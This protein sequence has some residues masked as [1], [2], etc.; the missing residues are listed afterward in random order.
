MK[1][2]L[3]KTISITLFSA[4]FMPLIVSAVTGNTNINLQVTGTPT[5][6][7]TPV[8][9]PG[10]YVD[11]IPPVIYSLS[12]SRITF[13]SAV[14]EWKTD[15]PALCQ[16]FWGTTQE[17]KEGIVSETAFLLSHTTSLI[18]LSVETN[19]NFKI[20]CR[21]SKGNESE[22]GNQRFTTLSLPDTTA[23]SNISNFE[24]V[25]GDKQITLQW[26]NPTDSDF[27]LVRIM[28]SQEFYP[29]NP[30]EG[31]LIFEGSTN[32]FTDTSLTNGTRYYYTAFSYD[33]AGNF[34][35][36]AV[37]SA[38]PRL[39]EIPPIEQIT[40]EKQ[41]LE[42]GFYW[43]DNSC[44]QEQQVIP[45]PPEVEKLTLDDFDFIQKGIKLFET[46][47]NINI[48][49]N[50]PL[51]IS[52]D[53]GKV[54][55]V[56]KT[57]MVTLKKDNKTFSFL[58]RINQEKTAYLA[59]L[60]P[61]SETGAYPAILSVLDY[62]NQILKKVSTQLTVKETKKPF[63]LISWLSQYYIFII[64]IA[65]IIFAGIA[66]FYIRKFKLNTAK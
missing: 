21:D 38:V 57:I 50:E 40:T 25:P 22:T 37:V 10:Q 66:Y 5:E 46:E 13:N 35:S 31:K 29:E 48:Q 1:N 15:E 3:K 14:I 42:S 9:P 20:V 55:E 41:C 49:E 27:K 16:V 62:Q 32:S 34:S 11:I 45:G 52:I 65:I 63:S 33:Y 59:S 53:Y 58:L 60:M 43:Y 44:H 8:P 6:P 24:A 23:P 2:E 18:S 7:V 39:G 36:G 54:P 51:T 47:G 19:Y 30:W 12:V 26:Q 17:Y 28:R 4:L 64:L 61:P 56:L